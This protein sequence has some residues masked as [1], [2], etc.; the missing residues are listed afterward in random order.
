MSQIYSTPHS[1]DAP[2]IGFVKAVEIQET[3][4]LPF[5]I[6]PFLRGDAKDAKIITSPERHV[7]CAHLSPERHWAPSGDIGHL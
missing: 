4:S 6:F 2:I 5:Y 7:H 1:F 3:A